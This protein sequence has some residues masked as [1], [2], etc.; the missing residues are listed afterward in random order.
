MANTFTQIRA[1]S[2]GNLAGDIYVPSG[3]SVEPTAVTFFWT[4]GSYLTDLSASAIAKG[5]LFDFSG[6]PD[7]VLLDLSNL[8]TEYPD[9]NTAY[10][11]A[12]GV[13]IPFAIQSYIDGLYFYS[14]TN[15]VDVENQ[16]VLYMPSIE[17]KM[18][19]LATSLLQ[20]QCQCKLDATLSDKFVKAKA[21]QELI[22][23][24]VADATLNGNT[25]AQIQAVLTD[26]NS[27]IQILTGFLEGTKKICGC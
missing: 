14:L 2:D 16:W 6:T 11:S 26:V 8:A 13:N 3:N 20:S 4:D 17:E 25:T 7:L 21:Y 12:A 10:F 24:K 9:G 19:T 15:A 27:D 22:Y 23:H 18:K 5:V 1:L